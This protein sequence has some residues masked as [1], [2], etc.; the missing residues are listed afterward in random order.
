MSVN[1]PSTCGYIHAASIRTIGCR[2][3]KGNSNMVIIYLMLPAGSGV[4]AVA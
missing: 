4:L 2:M 1:L 3:P